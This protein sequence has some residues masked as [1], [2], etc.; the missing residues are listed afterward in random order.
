MLLKVFASQ[1]G[2]TCAA[3]TIHDDGKCPS[4]GYTLRSIDLEREELEAMCL[5]VSFDTVLGLF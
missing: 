3:V 4:C 2:R 5:Q 1:T